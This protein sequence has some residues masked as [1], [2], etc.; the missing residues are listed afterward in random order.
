[1]AKNI[2]K[3]SKKSL[4]KKSKIEKHRQ[5]NP[6]LPA[7]L[8]TIALSKEDLDTFANL[9]SI[10]AKTFEQLAVQAA[11]N[12]DEENFLILQARHKLSSLFAATLIGASGMP[13]PTSRDVH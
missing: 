3:T 9:M 4:Q 2:K 13:E 7:G 12:K 8:V 10:C 1:M 11:T 6:G 5:I